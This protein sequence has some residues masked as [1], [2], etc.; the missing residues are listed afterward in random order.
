VPRL[1]TADPTAASALLLSLSGVIPGGIDPGGDCAPPALFYSSDAGHT[2]VSVPWPQAHLVACTVRA[3]L[4]EGRIYVHAD[5]PLLPPSQIPPGAH[6]RIIR[7][8]DFGATWHAAD[9][10][11][12]DADAFGIVGLRPRGRLLAETFDNLRPGDATLWESLS[13]GAFWTSLGRLPGAFPQIYVAGDPGQVANGGWGRLYLSAQE[14]NAGSPLVAADWPDTGWTH[15]PAL[16]PSASGSADP[17]VALG[18]VGPSDSLVLLRH[19][20]AD[21]GPA[22]APP[23]DIWLWSPARAS[24]REARFQLPAGALAEGTSWSSGMLRLWFLRAGAGTLA[25]PELLALDVPPASAA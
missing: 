24:W 6:A 12:P 1:V 7:S 22:V 20:I 3:S 18:A 13:A 16:P 25:T 21:D 2:W 23:L 15:L 17:Q 19:A 5:N 8:D 14:T 4:I 9:T 10:G 11:L